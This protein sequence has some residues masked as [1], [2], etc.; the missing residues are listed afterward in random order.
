MRDYKEI[1]EDVEVVFRFAL[2]EF[3][4]D[5]YNATEAVLEAIREAYKDG[6][7][8][9]WEMISATECAIALKIREEIKAHVRNI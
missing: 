2:K 3:K 7:S 1:R 6:Y 8:S 5:I 9:Q 4:G